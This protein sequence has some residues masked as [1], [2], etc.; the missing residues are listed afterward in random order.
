MRYVESL[1]RS[2]HAL[3][4]RDERVLFI[5]EDILDPYGGAFKVSKG[6][7]TRFPD[8]V[9][10]TPISEAGIV[11]FGSGLALRGFR[12]I[13]EIM[14]GD[15]IALCAD[16]IINGATK[17]SWMYNDQVRVPLVI[18]TPMGGRRGYGPTHSQS[19]ERLFFGV[20][21]LTVVAPSHMHMP[22]VCLEHAVADDRGPVL[23]IENK[24]LY[25]SHVLD[26]GASMHEDFSVRCIRNC[27]AKFP[28]MALTLAPSS[29]PDVLLLAYGGMASYAIDAAHTALMEHEVVVEVL[30]PSLVKPLPV[31][32]FLPSVEKCGRVVVC[33]EAPKASGWGAEVSACLTEA[34]FDRLHRPVAR[35]CST[36]T[37]IPS[38]MPL[39]ENVLPQ[40]ADLVEA[41]LLQVG[42]R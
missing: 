31:E 32:D 35:V 33:E 29:D 6:L 40:T 14:F 26:D 7:S 8:R 23:F 17:F 27:N 2:L 11:G 13:V 10:T 9:I 21:G 24:K 30:L 3:L 42:V 28:T 19:L 36:D 15:F 34:L 37:P 20:T 22:G 5:G 16:Q 1:N 39:E 12:P 4:E 41:I 25:P 38:S 18:R